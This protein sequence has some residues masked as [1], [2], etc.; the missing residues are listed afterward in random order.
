[1]NKMPKEAWRYAILLI[2]LFTIGALT[3]QA[4]LRFLFDELPLESFRVVAVLMFALTLGFMSIAGAFGMWAI[5]FSAERE[6][7]RRIGRM[8]DAMDYLR[9]GLVTLDDK[10]RITGANPSALEIAQRATLKDEGF[11]EVFPGVSEEDLHA[12]ID[13]REPYELERSLAC[14]AGEKTLRF[15]SQ[16]SDDGAQVLISDIT[17]LNA[18]V[19]HNRQMARFQL[20]GQ[21]ARGVAH[22]FSDL[23]CA[24]S[25]HASML[26]YGLRDSPEHVEAV[27]RMVREAEKGIA[28][29]AHLRELAQPMNVSRTTDVC[30]E[31]VDMA[32]RRV[33]DSLPD[34]W[35]VE[36]DIQ[37]VG[38][39]SLTGVQVEQIVLNL[40]LLCAESLSSP[41]TI[42][43]EQRLP[44]P[45]D[46]FEADGVYAGTLRVLAHCPAHR[47]AE[48]RSPRW[49][50]SDAESGVILS[51]IRSMIQE[52]GGALE[53]GR[54]EQQLPRYR[55]ALPSGTGSFTFENAEGDS[56]PY[57][58][59]VAEWTVLLTLA[60]GRRRFQVFRDR[61][62]DCKVHVR[63]ADNL[64]TMLAHT[65]KDESLDAVILDDTL[66][67]QEAESLLR[68]VVKLRPSAGFLALTER[69][70]SAPPSVS[71]EVVF[72]SADASPD[73]MLRA[74]I[75]SR[76]MAVRRMQAGTAPA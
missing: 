53:A 9:D 33:R 17:L 67:G 12:L 59:Y 26:R 14:P 25:G 75:E 63:E 32:V 50:A 35:R 27:D 68:A 3:V 72:V 5:R 56:R 55:V 51:V 65:E 11:C 20:V 40:A 19:A 66:F 61:L 58:A 13:K 1:M 18:L 64:M 52:A 7:Q 34:M 69:P 39:I 6:S 23:L 48:I 24:L 41:G 70:R 16:P 36:S 21:I 42:R 37:T 74:L 46:P 8:V 57:D 29:A 2:V 62:Q 47:E 71:G 38:T 10:G 54:T 4:I 31:Y 60:P 30:H 44:N 15:R 45:R 76:S 49:R 43:V 28:L 73:R 22:D